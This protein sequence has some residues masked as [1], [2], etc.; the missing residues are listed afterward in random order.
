MRL[1]KYCWIIPCNCNRLTGPVQPFGNEWFITFRYRMTES[2]VIM[3]WVHLNCAFPLRKL[4]SVE[5]ECLLANKQGSGNKL[6]QSFTSLHRLLSFSLHVCS[7]TDNPAA[8]PP[9]FIIPQSL[10]MH[11][12][13]ICDQLC[14]HYSH[15]VC[16]LPCASRSLFLS[17]CLGE[18]W[19]CWVYHDQKSAF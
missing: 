5:E 18:K 14:T 2:H 9:L 3:S 4:G 8:S 7:S 1:L 16:K 13:L 10:F 11:Y 6:P 17:R 15:H 19:P 12:Y